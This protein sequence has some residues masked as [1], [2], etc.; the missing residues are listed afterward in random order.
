MIITG[1]IYLLPERQRMFSANYTGR[2]FIIKSETTPAVKGA[3]ILER[4]AYSFLQL[5]RH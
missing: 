1:K 5:N 4:E 2:C 3:D